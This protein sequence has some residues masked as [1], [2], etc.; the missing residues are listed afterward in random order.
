VLLHATA[1]NPTGCDLEL[2]E[3]ADVLAVVRE[4]GLQCLFDMAYQGFTSGDADVDAGAVRL[5][6]EM[7]C[8]VLLAQSFSKNMGLY[9]HRVGCVSL[10]TGGAAEAA[11]VESQMKIIARP[12]WSNPPVA[13]VRLVDAVLGDERLE[14]MWRAEMKGM[15][16]RIMGMRARL[17]E[18]LEKA[19]SRREWGH[20]V[21]QNG[22]FCYSGLSRAQVD[23]LA[24]EWAVF[25]TAN[26]RMS[27]AGVFD[28][29]VEYLAKAVH[30]VTKDF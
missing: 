25:L 18:E 4:R 7:G 27:M 9:G 24:D 8:K 5:A 21:K 14:G 2:A 1:H 3:W 22:M 12:M 16:A 20:V 6:V 29:N 17:V 10:L 30:A 19:G 15:A 11:A 26:G 28:S 23:R 13:G